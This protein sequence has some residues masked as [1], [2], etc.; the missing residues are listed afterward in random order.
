MVT[1]VTGGQGSEYLY[2]LNTIG[3]IPS[4]SGPQTSNVFDNLG[5]GTY[6]VTISDS[7]NCFVTSVNIDITEPSPID[8]Q[9][10]L[11]SSQSCLT[12][13]TLTLSASG[14]TGTY[15]YSDTASFTTILGSFTSSTTFSVTDGTYMYYVRDTN[16]CISTVSNEITID[17]LPD[18]VIDLESEDPTINC[19]GDNTGSIVATALG[20]LGNY[21]YTLQDTGG[22][23]IPA[24]QNS[25]GVF[26]ELIAG[27]YV[28]YVESGDCNVAS[29]PITITEPSNPLVADFTVN[30]ITCSG[31]DDG[32]LTINASGGTGIIKYAISPQLDQF[33]ETN[34]FENLAAGDYDVIVQDEL[35]CYI[36]FDFTINNPEQVILSIVPD[37]ILEETCEGDVNG[38]F[39]IDISGGTLP[40][41]CESR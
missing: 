5:A 18:L 22:N 25:P 39:S 20:G 9:L 3:P 40:I 11:D 30:D 36:L 26:T 12:D 29:A 14:G 8:T 33:F 4:T 37:S 35:G 1:G 38:E 23:T 31:N 10:V 17:P 32:V 6:S 28:V 15:E 7:Y 21:V 27:T 19:T 16:G 2:T 34:V 24:T 41:Q 13:S